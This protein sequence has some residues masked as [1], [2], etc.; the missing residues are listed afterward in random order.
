MYVAALRDFLH[1]LSQP[2]KASGGS[3]SVVNDLDATAQGLEPFADLK[4]A[5]FAELLSQ[6]REYRDTGILP[7]KAGGR[8]APKKPRAPKVPALTVEAAVALV[9]SLQE[10]AATPEGTH[11]ALAEGL[12]PLNAMSAGD[13]AKLS[14]ALE[15]QKPKSKAK[16]LEAIRAQVAKRRQSFDRTRSIGGEG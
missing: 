3:A 13:I 8:A 2:V 6:A 12:N 4:F 5:E 7:V 11:D 10:K 1:S 15:L 14:A 9:V 16:G